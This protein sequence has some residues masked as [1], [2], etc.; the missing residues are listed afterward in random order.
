M[1]G[2]LNNLHIE[3]VESLSMEKYE[4]WSVKSMEKYKKHLNV[5]LGQL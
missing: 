2:H 5:V 1:A 3:D 4:S